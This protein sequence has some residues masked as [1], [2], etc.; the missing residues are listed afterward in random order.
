VA[1]ARAVDI[2]FGGH[3]PNAVG[4]HGALDARQ[5]TI[6][7]L[8][9]Y[10][11]AIQTEN[12][13]APLVEKTIRAG[14]AM[15]PTM[16][17]WEVLRGLHDPESMMGRPELGYM[18]QPM[19]AQWK[20]TVASI[21]GQTN[22]EQAARE[23]ELRN[24][25]LKAM[26]DAGVTLLLG[27]DAPQLFSVPGFSVQREMETWAQAGIAPYKI[28]QAGTTAVAKHLNDEANS[29]TISVGKR[30]DLLLV[31]ANPLQDVRNLARKSGVMFS[32]RWLPW[33][34]IQAQLAVQN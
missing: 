21:R 1:T 30:A 19:V 32:G 8:D 17:L 33:S 2:P 11:E 28:L 4:V 13:I 6:D 27:S 31:D 5:N 9:N 26:S 14:V 3:V 18:P 15:V 12:G 25:L 24:K 16:P 10:V 20:N 23:I 29:G 7:H 34:A 22:P